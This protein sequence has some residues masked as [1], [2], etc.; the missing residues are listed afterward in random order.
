MAF[1][2]LVPLFQRL[3][4]WRLWTVFTAGVVVA[5][6]IV[7]SGMEL[8]LKGTVTWDY[9]LTGLV[10]AVFAAPPA[11]LLLDHLLG[12]IA[13]QRQALLS[14]DLFAVE[15]RLQTAVHAARMGEWEIDLRNGLLHKANEAET[16]RHFHVDNCDALQMR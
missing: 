14:R 3:N 5:V 7:V 10:A 12:E 11:L 15:S 16:T 8:L 13:R 9:L 4:G 6:E 1:S 2:R